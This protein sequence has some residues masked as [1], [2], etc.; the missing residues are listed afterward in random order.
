ME[1]YE[2]EFENKKILITG[3]LGFI[4]SNLAHKLIQLNPQR[5]VVVDSL[6]PEC[7]GNE[8]NLDKIKEE[9]DIF[10]VDIRQTKTMDAIIRSLKP[11][12][13]FNLAGLL[14]HTE[15]LKDPKKD[16]EIN[17]WAQYNILEPCKINK[18]KVKIIYA[19]T[20]G[21]YGKDIKIMPITENLSTLK[22]ADPNGI[23]KNSGEQSC[24]FY[25]EKFENIS[26]CSLRMTNTYGP[27]HQMISPKQGFLNWFIRLAMDN[28]EISV[29]E[30]GSQLRD[31]NYVDDVVRALLMAMASNKTNNEVYNLGSCLND[32]Y[33]LKELCGNIISVKDVAKK[34][35]EICHEELGESGKLIMMPYP[36][37]MK[38]IEVGNIK[39]DFTKFNRDT[40]WKPLINLD[41]GLRKTIRFYNQ[42]KEK[43]WGLK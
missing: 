42:N 17:A 1:E 27:K 40:G 8:H 37:E 16:A 11:D 41:E 24:L 34:I 18:N 23:S 36:E 39:M 26:V 15:S 21:Q 7:G 33:E 4:G 10:N 29:Y 19:G 3:G 32:G 6:I 22:P 9:I 43:Y 30:P 28:K 38:K 35:T 14:S 31:F 2:K 25:G 5:I 12:F 13:I 20:R